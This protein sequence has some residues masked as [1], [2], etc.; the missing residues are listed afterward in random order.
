[1]DSWTRRRAKLAKEKKWVDEYV[2]ELP[3]L[4]ASELVRGVRYHAVSYHEWIA[5]CT[6]AAG[7]AVG[8]S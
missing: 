1:M 6:A 8:L 2:H 4:K 5:G 7:V 3:E